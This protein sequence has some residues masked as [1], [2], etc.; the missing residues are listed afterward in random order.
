LNV[1][2]VVLQKIQ[3]NNM[4][5]RSAPDGDAPVKNGK[6]KREADDDSGSDEVCLQPSK[7][8]RP[9]FDLDCAGF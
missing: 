3:E 4:S 8:S 5:K 2:I 6:G 7:P 9:S 1:F